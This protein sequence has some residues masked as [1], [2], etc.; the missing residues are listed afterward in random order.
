MQFAAAIS[1]AQPG[2]VH[3]PDPQDPKGS[4]G[5]IRK[6]AVIAAES[7]RTLF[8]EKSLLWYSVGSGLVIAFMF[9]SLYTPHVLA[10]FPYF[11]GD[12]YLPLGGPAV[13]ILTFCIEFACMLFFLSLLAGLVSSTFPHH[14]GHLT[15]RTGLSAAKKSLSRILLFAGIL[16]L[17][18]TVI[19]IVQLWYFPDVTF[20]IWDFL[21]RF[22]FYFIIKPEVYNYGPIGGGFHII[23]ALSTT[24]TLMALNLVCIFLTL[25]V[26]P[27]LVIEKKAVKDA[28]HESAVLL[29]KTGKEAAACILVFLLIICAFSATAL[30]FP[31][32]YHILK[33][34]YLLFWYPGVEWIAGAYIW[35]AAW[36]ILVALGLTAAG[37]AVQKLYVSG[38]KTTITE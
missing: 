16:S 14:E 27:V 38:S 33:P 18:V 37:I 12:P 7:F 5:R 15:I 3:S 24:F 34:E 2:I 4:P 30:F 6:G 32:I 19:F 26:V 36:L 13:V 20:G 25:F 9:L 22:P 17:I 10:G 35:M 8:R 31:V 21:S 28:V 29:K 11:R 1:P 23:S